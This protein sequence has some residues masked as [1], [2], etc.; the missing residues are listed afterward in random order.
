MNFQMYYN[1][2][3]EMLFQIQ[4][5]INVLQFIVYNGGETLWP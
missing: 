5:E 1:Y 2:P 3:N 4:F